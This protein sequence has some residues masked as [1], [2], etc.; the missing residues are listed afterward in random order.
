[1]SPTSPTTAEH[2]VTPQAVAPAQ[3]RI[4]DGPGFRLGSIFGI[5]IRI[6]YSWFVIFFLVLWTLTR[7]VFPTSYP[8]QEPLVYLVMGTVGTLLLFTSLLAHEL[9]HSLLSRSRDLPVEGITL[10]MFG[11]MAHAS[12]EFK[13]PDDE[14]VIA[15]VGPLSSLGIAALFW[16]IARAGIELGLPP[17]VLAVASYLALIN[18]VLAVFNLFPGF[19]LDGGRLLRA[20][21][22][23]RTG[24]LRRATRVATNGG[25]ILGYLL[26]VLGLL[27][28]FG[29]NPVGGL[30]LLLIGWFIRFAADASY[31]QHVLRQSLQDVRAQ[32]LMTPHPHT[33]PPDLGLQQFVD[34]HVLDG[35]HHSY[36]VL[37]GAEPIGLITLPLVRKVPKAE[38]PAR[39][40]GEA[41][42]PI[43]PDLVAGPEVAMSDALDKLSRSSVQRLLVTHDGR[44]LGIIS[45]ADVSR[46]LDR[47]RLREELSR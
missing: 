27:N 33:V 3:R 42:M 6:D 16:L 45:H 15:G 13:S 22:W 11:G 26:M 37:A 31:T 4:V 8:G 23:K 12:G 41:M 30:W 25:K 29:G 21:V 36:P 28:L 2:R 10:F 24:D 47:E 46:W 7:G 43:G 38:W 40:V 18:L 1:V 5:E 9:S 19:P 20:L 17:A 14:F 34:E 39:T 32:D 35:F 44:L